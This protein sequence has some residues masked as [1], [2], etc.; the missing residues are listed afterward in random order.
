ML[1]RTLAMG[2]SSSSRPS[3][4]PFIRVGTDPDTRYVK[5]DGTLLSSEEAFTSLLNLQKY[6]LEYKLGN[7]APTLVRKVGCLLAPAVRPGQL[8]PPFHSHT[9]ACC[10]IV[11]M[12]LS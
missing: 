4:L 5:D 12:W 10:R 9:L 6:I 1:E 7:T 11:I 8:S 2:F 3:D